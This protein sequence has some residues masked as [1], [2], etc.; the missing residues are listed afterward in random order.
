[1]YEKI[2]GKLEISKNIVVFTGAGIS[3][4]SGIPD[5]RSENGL[6]SENE[7][8]GYSPEQILSYSFF[9]RNTELFY[10][11]YFEKIVHISAKPNKGHR[12]LANLEKRG[13]SISIITQNI[14]GLHTAAGSS[15]VIELH[16]SVAKNYCMECG[17]KYNLDLLIEDS[18]HIPKCK[19]CNGII[20]PDV[21]LYEEMLNQSFYKKA[22]AMIY[23]ADVLFAIGSSLVVQ[24]AASLIDYF[25]GDLFVI[26][27]KEATPYD[28]KADY[29]IHDSCGNVLETLSGDNYE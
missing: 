11:Y 4:E 22:A 6:Y 3:T 15:N 29:I 10:R 23:K 1:M 18:K 13:F 14:D 16:G 24:P 12:A 7:F 17:T 25:R 8:K 19:V 20:R 27:N 26:I 28:K 9:I 21:T 2:K 5:F